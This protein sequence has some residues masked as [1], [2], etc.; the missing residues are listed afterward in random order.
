MSFMLP[1]NFIHC[2]LINGKLIEQ[3]DNSPVVET[4]FAKTED[5]SPEYSILKNL[6][7]SEDK[8][9]AEKLLFVED[10]DTYLIC[11]TLLRLVLSRKLKMD[12]NDIPIVYD[13]NN[14][15][16]LEGN[17]L[18][19]NISHTRGAFVFAISQSSRVGVDLEKTDRS[20]DFDSIIK[21]FFCRRECEFILES[22]GD[23]INRFFL[24]WTRK[25][26]LL[27]AFGTGIVT[28]HLKIEVFGQKNILDRK[29][30]DNVVDESL[31]SDYFIY[32]K[33]ILDYYISIAAPQKS[34][35]IIY[36]TDVGEAINSNYLLSVLRSFK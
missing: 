2:H 26:A 9:K 32:S 33:K 21:R 29:M 34:K 10:R 23:S 22:P 3:D 27:K 16:W 12:P 17:S 1:D 4:F 19:F 24:L 18:F 20:I 6:I 35:V 25:E 13:K 11:H 14:K 7:N 28:N 5:L 36:Q 8:L 30:F 31:F 15:P